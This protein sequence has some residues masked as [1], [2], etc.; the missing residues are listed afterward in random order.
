MFRVK[1]DLCPENVQGLFQENN[2]SYN[3][4]NSD[5]IIPR[6]NTVKYGKHSLKYAGPFFWS[7]L[8]NSTKN[9]I[10]FH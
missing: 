6:Y 2:S 9:P 4:R 3:L 5:F 8:M 10:N 1:H 7:K